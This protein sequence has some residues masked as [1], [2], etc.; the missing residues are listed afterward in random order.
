MKLS[1]YG[2]IMLKRGAI[3]GT[4]ILLITPIINSRTP[5]PSKAI[6]CKAFCRTL[7][8]LSWNSSSK[9]QII[10]WSNNC[11]NLLASSFLIVG[12]N[13]II[14]PLCSWTLDKYSFVFE[15]SGATS[16]GILPVI[17]AELGSACS[18]N[19]NFTIFTL[20]ITDANNNG[21]SPALGDR[22]FTSAPFSINFSAIFWSP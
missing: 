8:K 3:T 18:F 19:K 1:K 7:S 21:V 16:N 12:R 14:F 5:G 4:N 22:I 10:N 6:N 20:S 17:S 9:T 11:I 13:L 2:V 15:P